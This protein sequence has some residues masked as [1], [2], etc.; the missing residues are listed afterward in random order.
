MI[1]NIKT[2]R[3]FSVFA[4]ILA[5]LAFAG[6][7][8][9][10]DIF[11]F[12]GFT[13]DQRNSPTSG[14][15]LGNGVELGG[16]RFSTNLPNETTAN[17]V[18]FPQGGSGFITSQGLSQ[19]TGLASGLR[20]VNLPRGN[21]D[22]NS[23]STNRHGIQV[24][25]N[26]GRV[27][28]NLPG[29]DFVIYESGSTSNGVEG[30]MARVRTNSL[31]EAWTDWY[32]F[33]PTNYQH[34]TNAEVAFAFSFDLSGMGIA[35]GKTADRVQ[36]ANLTEH[37]RI[38]TT[39]AVDLGGVFVGEGKVIFDTNASNVLPDA[40]PFDT[41]RRYGLGAYDPDP[42]YIAALHRVCEGHDPLLSIDFVGDNLRVSWPAPSCYTLQSCMAL[43]T[44]TNNWVAPT[45]TTV[46][47]NGRNQVLVPNDATARFFRLV[48]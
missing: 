21:N 1:R 48:K 19:L 15:L 12:A 4:T 5:L 23:M 7:V 33:A 44:P 13:F 24:S 29:I 16:A 2:T 39:N 22:G 37:D 14:G 20:G 38:E 45:E 31:P 46:V 26:N 18:N 8:Q 47:T 43:T 34:T 11:T 3:Q 6:S 41:N 30:L 36:I 27:L 10:A 42:F 28:N 17:S 9:A 35:E 40:G 25:W 32:Y